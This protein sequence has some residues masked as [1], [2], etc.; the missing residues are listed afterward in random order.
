[1]AGEWLDDRIREIRERMM[2]DDEA[3]LWTLIFDDPAG[4]PLLAS[5][6]EGAMSRLD[7]DWLSNF[8]RILEE[9]GAAAYLLAVIRHDGR[10][11]PED[12]QLW[13]EL[14]VL[15]RDGASLLLGFVVVGAKRFWCAPGSEAP[16]AA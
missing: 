7:L 15:L 11:R 9:V 8:A 5:A 1:M 13:R 10:P 3:S 12:Q 16:A 14:Q 6:F 2:P 4:E